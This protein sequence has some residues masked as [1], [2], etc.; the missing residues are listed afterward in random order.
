MRTLHGIEWKPD[1]KQILRLVDDTA[2]DDGKIV[3]ALRIR[4]DSP[5][6]HYPIYAE[7]CLDMMD[8]FFG[9]TGKYERLADDDLPYLFDELEEVW[10]Y[11]PDSNN[12]HYYGV[13]TA[14]ISESE[15]LESFE[16]FN[17][18]PF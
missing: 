13:I 9:E 7:N 15:F 5:E 16:F 17:L 3:G 18:S 6:E 8:C 11:Y 4:S 14:N 12:I 2:L 10:A 1:Y